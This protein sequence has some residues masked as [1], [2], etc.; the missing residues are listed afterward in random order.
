MRESGL[1]Q[2]WLRHFMPNASQCLPEPG[3]QT[4]LRPAGQSGLS[5]TEIGGA[6]MLLLIG[7]VVAAAALLFERAVRL[8]GTACRRRRPHPAPHPPENG[9]GGQGGKVTLMSTMY[10]PRE[11][12][13]GDLEPAL[14]SIKELTQGLARLKTARHGSVD[15]GY[16]VGGGK[17]RQ[18]RRDSHMY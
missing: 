10:P 4:R 16:G 1:I 14:T 6:F 13:P 3:A 9:G 15:D 8:L 7:L 5:M 2:A 17:E 11:L 12:R 18:I